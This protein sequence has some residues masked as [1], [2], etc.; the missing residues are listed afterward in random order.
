M[1]ILSLLEALMRLFLRIGNKQGHNP[2]HFEH[3]KDDEKALDKSN[4]VDQA[5]DTTAKRDNTNKRTG[6]KDYKA[7]LNKGKMNNN[8]NKRTGKKERKN[9]NCFA[10]RRHVFLLNYCMLKETNEDK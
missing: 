10:V 3:V 5:Y 6:D 8:N 1:W 2:K 4:N 9:Y 7:Q